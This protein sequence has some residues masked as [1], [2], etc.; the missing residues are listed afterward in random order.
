[1]TI[2]EL[3]RLLKA[4]KNQEVRK[5]KQQAVMDHRL[6]DLIGRSVARVYS[7][8]VEIPNVQDFYDFLFDEEDLRAVQEKK[9]KRQD[10]L[11]AIRFKQFADSFNKRF[12]TPGKEVAND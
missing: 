9:Q 4:K 1:M 8:N 10:E 12:T 7:N 11:S 5:L 3:H 6:A 2:A